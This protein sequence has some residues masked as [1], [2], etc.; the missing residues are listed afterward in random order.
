MDHICMRIFL[1]GQIRIQIFPLGRIQNHFF[2]MNILNNTKINCSTLIRTK[3]TDL[4]SAT[5]GV[6]ALPEFDDLDFPSRKPAAVK[7]AT[8]VKQPATYKRYLLPNLR[9]ISNRK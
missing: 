4:E 7:A 9:P 8:A 1:I 6:P 2:Y 3:A 5:T